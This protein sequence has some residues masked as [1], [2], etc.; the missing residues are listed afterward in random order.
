MIS[1]DKI[2]KKE[3]KLCTC[4]MTVHNVL[5]VEAEET[6]KHKGREVTYPAV[7]LYCDITDEYFVHGDMLDQNFVS[8]RKAYQIL[9][10]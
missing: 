9:Q 1:N 10:K 2:I 6:T 4:C 8:M 3:H 7:Y 5:T